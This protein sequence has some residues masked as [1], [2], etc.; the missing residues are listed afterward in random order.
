MV[1]VHVRPPAR[2]SAS[3]SIYSAGNAVSRRV[4]LA[5]GRMRPSYTILGCM[6][7]K[8]DFQLQQNRRRPR[9]SVGAPQGPMPAPPL[10]GRRGANVVGRRFQASRLYGRAADALAVAGEEGRGK[11]RKAPGRRMRSLIRGCPNGATRHPT[12]CRLVKRRDTRR[13]ETSQ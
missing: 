1:R 9:F 3:A 2:P 12:G 6:R 5:T 13:S 4:S 10:P 11:L 8:I 7:G